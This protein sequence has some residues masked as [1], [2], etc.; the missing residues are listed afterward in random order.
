[1]IYVTPRMQRKIDKYKTYLKLHQIDNFQHNFEEDDKLH[2]YS[3]CLFCGIFTELTK[4]HLVPR[5]FSGSNHPEN[6][7]LVCNNCN[8]LKGDRTLEEWARDMPEN[9][10]YRL[11]IEYIIQQGIN[12]SFKPLHFK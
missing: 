7:G 5:A 3:S 4:D 11:A 12:G 10:K 9:S 6:I 1:M 2:I 8:Q